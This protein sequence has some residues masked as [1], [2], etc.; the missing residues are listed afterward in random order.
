MT[1]VIMSEDCGNSPK[2][3]LLKD[4]TIAFAKGGSKFILQSVTNEIKWNFVGYKTYQGKEAFT[5]Y[6]KGISTEKAAEV[7]IHQI[8]TH[9]ASGAIN[10]EV[11]LKNGKTYYIIEIT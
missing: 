5:E 11:K 4:L 3:I 7:K 1:K 9:G 6:V 8:S 10:G 2:N